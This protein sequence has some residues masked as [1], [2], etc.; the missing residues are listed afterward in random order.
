MG[1][2]KVVNS[3]FSPIANFSQILKESLVKSHHSD[4]VE[5]NSPQDK[6]KLQ[7]VQQQ[8]NPVVEEKEEDKDDDSEEFFN[9]FEKNYVVKF[10]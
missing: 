9:N 8:V 3:S 4:C 7:P 5:S 10:E 2:S 1:S 6:I